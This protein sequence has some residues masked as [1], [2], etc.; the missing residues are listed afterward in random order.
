MSVGAEGE[1]EMRPYIIFI[2]LV[3]IPL[4]SSCVA[5]PLKRHPG[6]TSYVKNR[7]FTP[8]SVP[9]SGL[10]IG[11]VIRR[12]ESGIE[13]LVASNEECLRFTDSH[14]N[15]DRVVLMDVE[16]RVTSTSSFELALLGA[17]KPLGALGLSDADVRGS[18]ERGA[19]VKISMRNPR[20]YRVS[21]VSLR[22]G[23][24]ALV[25]TD[26]QACVKA[27]QK[28]GAQV[29]TSVFAVRDGILF[30]V[31]ET[32]TGSYTIGLGITRSAS[33]LANRGSSLDAH[34]HIDTELPIHIGYRAHRVAIPAGFVS[35]TPRSVGI[36]R[37]GAR[38]KL[39]EQAER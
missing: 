21:D 19:T 6:L 26:A 17:F 4:L 14:I 25:N 2:A 13:R 33:G 38:F 39:P 35:I 31:Q 28:P 10:G 29:I 15:E 37:V 3:S 5:D 1:N 16:Y 9:Q 7:G 24:A 32:R 34:Q 20:V 36:Q 27:L 11:S 22:N 23:V 18:S 8:Y 30:R 12:G